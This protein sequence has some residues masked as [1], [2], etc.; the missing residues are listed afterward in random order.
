MNSKL[1][2]RAIIGSFSDDGKIPQR[3]NVISAKW[4]FAWKTDSDG[5]ITEA[6]TSLIARGIRQQLGV[7]YFEAFAPTPDISS[8]EVIL[9]V[10]VK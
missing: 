2:G 1:E 10:V 5:L 7:D 9:V 6:T 3:M 8:I 4:A